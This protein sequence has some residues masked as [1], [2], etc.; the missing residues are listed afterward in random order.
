MVCSLSG[1]IRPIMRK[2][3]VQFVDWNGNIIASQE[4]PYGGSATPPANPTREGYTFIGWDT[5]FSNI[6]SNITVKAVYEK[7]PV[8]YTITFLY[9]EDSVLQTS[10]VLEGEMPVY[11]GETPYRPADQKYTYTFI[12]W[13][14]ELAVVT[15][16]AEY[17]AMFSIT[18]NKYTITFKDEDG[19]VLSSDQWEYGTK[20]TCEI[21]TKEE[22]EQY[23]YLF[24]KWIPDVIPV[25]G[26]AIYTASYTAIPIDQANENIY[27]DTETARKILLDGHILILRGDRTYTLTGQE[28]K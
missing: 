28:V 25:E 11:T 7:I 26:D 16:D 4:V 27:I 6:S 24:A 14:P 1:A 19:S 12:G 3:T 23:R 22:D 8:Y 17:M 15:G 21:P 20:P 13:Y 10:Q 5:D 9:R 18:L 2:Y